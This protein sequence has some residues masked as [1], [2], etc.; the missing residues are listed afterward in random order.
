MDP[1][2]VPSLPS[3]ISQ[4][5]LGPYL[6]R[7]KGNQQY[8]L[9]LYAWNIELTAAFLGPL[10]M[11][12]VLVRNSVHNAMSAAIGAAFWWENPRVYLCSREEDMFAT[13][14]TKLHN[15]GNQRPSADDILAA[16]NFGL[17]SGLLDVG[18]ARDS[19][20]DYETQLWPWIEPAFPHRSRDGRRQIHSRLNRIR[21]FRNRVMHHEPI[22]NAGYG[23][24]KTLIV[25]TA[26]LVD[27][28]VGNYIE[29]SQRVDAVDARKQ[30]AVTNGDCQF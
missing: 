16:T 22:F 13:A 2:L 10:G 1:H 29:Q 5:R 26:N 11:L 25:E 6:A 27:P 8:A 4:P 23:G 24:M 19:L 18:I 12:E 9:R 21:K 20:Y 14:A 17:W 30:D 15:S 28:A 7:Y 3:A